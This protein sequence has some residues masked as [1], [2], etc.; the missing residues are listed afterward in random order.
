MWFGAGKRIAGSEDRKSRGLGRETADRVEKMAGAGDRK[1]RGLGRETADRVGKRI[2]GP[3]QTKKDAILKKENH[4]GFL[5]P[6]VVTMW[7]NQRT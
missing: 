3:D 6:L 2:A 5:I 4:K 1:S 7:S